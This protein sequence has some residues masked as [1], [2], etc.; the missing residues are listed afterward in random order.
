MT[1][2]LTCGST[3]AL[4]VVGPVT[5][6][7]KGHSITC[8]GSLMVGL[9]LGGSNATIKDGVVTNC[10]D[11]VILGGSGHHDVQSLVVTTDEPFSDV[12]DKGGIAFLVASDQN[13]LNQNVARNT[14][15]Q[16][17]TLIQNGIGYKVEGNKNQLQSNAAANSNSGFLVLGS[18]NKLSRNTTGDCLGGFGVSGSSNHLSANVAARSSATGF[19]LKGGSNNNV[20]SGNTS[21]ATVDDPLD[22]AT[23][24]GIDVDFGADGN[25]L[26]NNEALS[27][28]AIGIGVGGSHNKMTGNRAIGNGLIDLD[29]ASSMTNPCG[30]N[31]WKDNVFGPPCCQPCIK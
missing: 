21:F 9:A 23:G 16:V 13:K 2:D 6:D 20:L 28:N 24:D 4:L 15:S 12:G 29:D 1:T 7:M 27:N 10:T 26:Q 3:F 14:T 17:A 5:L 8:S 31:V 25:V 30:T 11:G 19:E 18:G 22:H